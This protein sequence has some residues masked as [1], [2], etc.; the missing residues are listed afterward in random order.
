MINLKPTNI[1]LKKRVISIVMDI[2][3]CSEEDAVKGLEANN[4]VIKDTICAMGK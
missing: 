2:M 1:K 4:W 3:E